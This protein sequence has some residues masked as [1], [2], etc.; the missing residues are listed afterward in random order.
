MQDL[1]HRSILLGVTVAIA[2]SS[3][4]VNAAPRAAAR[5]RVAVPGETDLEGQSR[6]RCGSPRSRPGTSARPGR[7]SSARRRRRFPLFRLVHLQLEIA[8]PQAPAQL[9]RHADAGGR[10]ARRVSQAAPRR[11]VRL[12]AALPGRADPRG[13]RP[14]AGSALRRARWRWPAK[15]ASSAR[16]L[17][18][19]APVARQPEPELPERRRHFGGRGRLLPEAPRGR[20]PA[21]T[22]PTPRS[23]PRRRRRRP[24]ATNAR[25]RRSAP[26]PPGTSP[27]ARPAP[28]LR[29]SAS[30]RAAPAPGLD[31]L[32]AL[33]PVAR[34][35][36]PAAASPGARSRDGPGCPAVSPT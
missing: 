23:A 4:V 30:G 5:Q 28:R 29:R 27:G 31:A 33:L 12:R 7:S 9:Q 35:R 2:H 32:E 17:V 22:P 3:V 15:P 10:V 18:P 34:D 25:A 24:T 11:A 21:A 19:L 20:P 6:A 1:Q 36:C 16:G 14:H 26:A 13:E 8:S